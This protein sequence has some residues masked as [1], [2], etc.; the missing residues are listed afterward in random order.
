[1]NFLFYYLLLSS[2]NLFIKLIY[3]KANEKIFHSKLKRE[4]MLI[5]ITKGANILFETGSERRGTK[6]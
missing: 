1:M 3:F 5:D 6:T 4:F 2:V